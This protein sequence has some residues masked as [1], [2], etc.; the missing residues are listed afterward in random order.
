MGATR[1]AEGL[2]RSTG[3]PRPPFVGRSRELALLRE[4]LAAAVQGHGGVTLLL[5]EPGIGKTRLAEEL[6][7]AAGA[8][9]ARVLWGRCWEGE[10]APAFWPWVQC[11]RSYVRDTAAD[12]LRADLGAGAGAIAHVVE[13][14][15]TRL[16]DVPTPAPLA[17]EQAR[18]RFFDAVTA[19]LT[20][21]A[22]RRP[23]LVILDDLHWADRP[24]L[25][26]VQFL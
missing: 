1:P 26:L 13:E 11:L 7:A 9:G 6:G 15:R 24:S 22:A 8:Q 21:A 14:V 3:M 12:V 17:P 2:P 19:F 16:P 23:L 10:G 18:F 5:G 25:L 20:A 4:R